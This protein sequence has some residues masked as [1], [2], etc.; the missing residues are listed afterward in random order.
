[1]GA[2][3]DGVL[4]HGLSLVVL[5]YSFRVLKAELVSQRLDLVDEEVQSNYY[6]I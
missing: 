3:Q 6:T 5:R 2:P 1:M 4:R